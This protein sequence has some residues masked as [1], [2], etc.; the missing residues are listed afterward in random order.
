MIFTQL[1]AAE[2]GWIVII[3]GILSAVGIAT[4]LYLAIQLFLFIFVPSPIEVE[5]IEEDEEEPEV[6]D[7]VNYELTG[8]NLK[9]HIRKVNDLWSAYVVIGDHTSKLDIPDNESLKEIMLKA[10]L[11]LEVKSS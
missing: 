1:S 4:L 10:L 2:L 6:T 8:Q 11:H 9:V 3:G 5:E 7:L